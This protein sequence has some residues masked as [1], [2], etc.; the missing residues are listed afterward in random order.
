MR[1][2]SNFKNKSDIGI[3]FEQKI[4]WVYN[5]IKR[6]PRKAICGRIRQINH[7]KISYEKSV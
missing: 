1:H 6:N 4:V 3:V 5:N 7:H 2:W